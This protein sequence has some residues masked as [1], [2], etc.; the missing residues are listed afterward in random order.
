M[1]SS[2]FGVPKGVSAPVAGADGALFPSLDG[3]IR[4]LD[5]REEGAGIEEIFQNYGF[6]V[7]GGRFA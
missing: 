3:S 2:D 4:L 7:M 6:L 5:G 1:R